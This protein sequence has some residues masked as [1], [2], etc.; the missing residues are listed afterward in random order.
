MY[1]YDERIKTYSK[2]LHLIKIINVFLVYIYVYMYVY[3]FLNSRVICQ[4]KSW[5]NDTV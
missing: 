3:I 5:N 4:I 2:I 1:I